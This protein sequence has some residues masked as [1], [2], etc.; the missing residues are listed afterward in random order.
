MKFAD[1]FR[2][3]SR[4]QP[5]VAGEPDYQV[6][7]VP[8]DVPIVAW[9]DPSLPPEAYD[10]VLEADAAFS[11]D[12]RVEGQAW[13]LTVQ[14]KEYRIRTKARQHGKGPVV[15]EMKAIIDGL[16]EA[17]GHG[18]RSVI[19][20]T[21]NSWCAHV[22]VGLW[23][24]GLPHTIGPAD[25]AVELLTAFDTVA[26][27]HTRTKTMRRVDRAARSAADNRR[28]K[29]NQS[30]RRRLEAFRKTLTR[31]ETVKLSPA[32][33]GWRANGNFDVTVRPPSCTCPDWSLRWR[34]VPLSGR[35]ARRN[36]CK[37]IAAAAY[38]EGI[39]QPE[40]IL[41]LARSAIS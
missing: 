17:A 9:G 7:H 31:A 2:D 21:D 10:A 16:T 20:K 36:P 14:G 39:T 11:Y 3:S 15:A 1:F 5:C 37:H 30:G 41:A 18:L 28:R 24:P 23:K 29:L 32:P 38:A 8:M 35:R 40:D 25:E 4:N 13:R 26:V 33:G 27:V 12:D 6:P 34:D 19:V 22:L